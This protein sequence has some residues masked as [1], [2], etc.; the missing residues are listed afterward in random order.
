MEKNIN[1]IK[2]TIRTAKAIEEDIREYQSYKV[3]DAYR[4]TQKRITLSDRK[5]F[6]IKYLSRVAVI[7]LLPL[8]TSTAILSYLFINNSELQEEIAYYSV[9]S[10]PGLVT[11]LEL[12]DRSKVWLNAGSTLRYPSRFDAKKREVYLSGEGY[13][14]VESDQA[15]PFY[16]IVDERIKVKAYGTKFNVNSYNDDTVFETVL[17]SGKVD[18]IIGDKPLTLN[19]SESA[20]FNKENNKVSVSKIYTDEKTSWKDGRLIFRNTTLE[21]VVKKL[22][23]R[24]N[25]DIVLHRESTINYRFRASFTNETITQVLNYMKLAAPLEWTFSEP[26]QLHDSSYERQRIDLWLK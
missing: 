3:M 12:P 5:K 4:Q 8:L 26:E 17:E 22:S 2:D 16:V 1:S 9:N 7:L 11:Q 25:V 18:V 23:R 21:D 10:A 13:F 6:V 14:D 24:Y 20:S 19:E 15:S